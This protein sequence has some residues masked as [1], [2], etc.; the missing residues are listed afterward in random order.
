M[1]RFLGRWRPATLL[2]SWVGYWVVLAAITMGPGIVAIW[3]ATQS[4][5]GQGN[6]SLN[7]SNGL[8]SLVVQ[9]N[10][11][12]TY[13]GSAHLLAIALLVGVPPLVLFGLWLRERRSAVEMV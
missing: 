1:F 5:P 3:K 4:G 10:G 11:H 9:A 2:A 6:V 12:T 8:F 13:T 7:F